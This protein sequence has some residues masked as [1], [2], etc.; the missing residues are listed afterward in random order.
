MCLMLSPL[1][2]AII[3][4]HVFESFI[5]GFICLTGRCTHGY[6][7]VFVEGSI[8]VE[9]FHMMPISYHAYITLFGFIFVDYLR[10]TE[11]LLYHILTDQVLTPID[12]PTPHFGGLIWLF[13]AG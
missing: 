7:V 3:P 5:P 12:L 4:D 13:V 6:I 9:Y 2:V 11:A 8:F 1:P 10:V